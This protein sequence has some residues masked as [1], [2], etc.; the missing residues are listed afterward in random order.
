ML[1]Q[2]IVR[3]WLF[4]ATKRRSCD[5]PQTVYN[6]IVRLGRVCQRGLL[7]DQGPMIVKGVPQPDP[8]IAG[9]AAWWVCLCLGQPIGL[10][11]RVCNATPVLGPVLGAATIVNASIAA[12][13]AT[14]TVRAT[15][16]GRPRYNKFGRRPPQSMTCKLFQ[17]VQ[18]I[19]SAVTYCSNW[20]SAS[21]WRAVRRWA[22]DRSA[23]QWHFQGF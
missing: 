21:W 5:A 20:K 22:T 12:G 6:C 17:S 15:Q 18:N 16:W 3:A 7:V 9:T 10:A 8:V 4:P 2:H 1:P 14:R 11:L 23:L 13:E 19:W